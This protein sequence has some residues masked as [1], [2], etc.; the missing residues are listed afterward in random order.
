MDGQ[1]AL[2]NRLGGK[3]RK[4]F[5]FTG[6]VPLLLRVCGAVFFFPAYWGASTGTNDKLDLEI[7]NINCLHLKIDNELDENIYS[8]GNILY[9]SKS[10]HNLS[11]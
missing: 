1:A 2:L 3:E 5:P 9:N 6:S 8:H 7:R 11:I 10:N 4:C